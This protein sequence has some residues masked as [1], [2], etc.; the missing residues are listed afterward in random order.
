SSPPGGTPTPTRSDPPS[1]ERARRQSARG[2]GPGSHRLPGPFR[3]SSGSLLG[4]VVLLGA[5]HLG[6]LAGVAVLSTDLGEVGV[7][8]GAELVETTRLAVGDVLPHV[9]TDLR[10][11]D[12]Q[13]GEVDE[14]A[15]E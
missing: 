14:A 3:V 1:S 9:L 7:V 11:E 6:Q 5:L 13:G 15:D 2:K 10:Q 12:V 4:V 8:L